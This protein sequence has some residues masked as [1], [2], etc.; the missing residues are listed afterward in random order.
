[1]FNVSLSLISSLSLSLSLS[2]ARSLAL[3]YDLRLRTTTS[4]NMMA[5][6]NNNFYSYP[7]AHMFTLSSA[8]LCPAQTP[9]TAEGS[10]T[11]STMPPSCS[12]KISPSPR[13]TNPNLRALAAHTCRAARAGPTG[14]HPPRRRSPRPCLWWDCPP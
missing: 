7:R 4:Y 12:H 5:F 6:Y 9:Q 3:Q 1:M 10:R 14:R 2:L 11:L 8:N 13:R